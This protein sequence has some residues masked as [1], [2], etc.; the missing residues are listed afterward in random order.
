MSKIKSALE[1]ALEKTQDVKITDQELMEKKIKEVSMETASQFLKD[2]K[3]DMA[4]ALKNIDKK[5]YRLALDT[6]QDIFLK[7][8]I[9]P[10]TDLQKNNLELVF[11]G[12]SVIKKNT[13]KLNKV[14]SEL[15]QLFQQYKQQKE[16]VLEQLKKQMGPMIQQT[17][18]QIAEQMGTNVVIDPIQHPEFQ[19][20]F[21]N[22]MNQINGQFTE[23]LNKIKDLIR[24]ID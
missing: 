19:K 22:Y 6:I 21:K 8:I 18:K 14:F 10:V 1:I 15:D 7:N 23:Y 2:N 4:N 3:F 9:L 13:N 24:S 12:L 16:S 20:Q 17:Q 5:Y 11:S